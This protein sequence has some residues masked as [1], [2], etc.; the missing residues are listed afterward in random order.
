VNSTD[1]NA[2]ASDYD[3]LADLFLAE[4][5]APTASKPPN[6]AKPENGAATRYPQ[7]R[8]TLTR[9]ELAPRHIGVP[10]PAAS[11]A[12]RLS[13]SAAPA[14]PA[15]VEGVIAGHLPVL[16]SAWVTQYARYEADQAKEPV[17]LLRLEGDQVWLDVVLPAGSKPPPGVAAAPGESLKAVAQRAAFLWRRWL[18]RVDQPA[19]SDLL[20]IEGLS[21][22]ALLTGADDAAV[23]ASYQLIKNL[24]SVAGEAAPPPLRLVVMG[25]AD[26]KAGEAEQSL[27]RAAATFLRTSIESTARVGKI[28]SAMA[29]QVYRGPATLEIFD[30]LA[31]IRATRGVGDAPR[32][33]VP[34]SAAPPAIAIPKLESNKA[35]APNG[36][37][38]RIAQSPAAPSPAAIPLMVAVPQ[39]RTSADPVALRIPGLSGLGID[40]PYAKGVE[41]ASAADGSLHLIA[42]ADGA[43]IAEASQRLL[44]AAAWAS[45][46]AK[47]LLAAAPSLKS[48]ADPILHVLTSD[49]KQARGLLDT[50][51]R[52]HLATRVELAGQVAWAMAD[53]N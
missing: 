12:L 36:R 14:G 16:G 9:P 43:P 29:V 4:E 40:C 48:A 38:P 41:L 17:A 27:T 35:A 25:A 13:L 6:G 50:G 8:L 39:S 3:A 34:K 23:V 53:L 30:L 10:E 28:G 51:L 7:P 20:A 1:F 15:H 33:A 52:V 21:S 24:A 46:H 32:I 45:A 19:E 44:T 18:V 47:L 26:P 31:I 11:P 37:A 5:P 42:G 22:V 2:P 49:A